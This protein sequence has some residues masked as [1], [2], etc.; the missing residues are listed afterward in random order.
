[1][2]YTAAYGSNST[3]TRGRCVV[4]EKTKKKLTQTRTKK[5]RIKFLYKS[6]VCMNMWKKFYVKFFQKQCVLVL[7]NYGHMLQWQHSR[8]RMVVIQQKQG[9]PCFWK[10]K[11]NTNTK[12]FHIKCLSMQMMHCKQ[13]LS[14]HGSNIWYVK[15]FHANVFKN[16]VHFVFVELRPYAAVFLNVTSCNLDLLSFNYF[17]FW[18]LQKKRGY[19][20]NF[21]N[22]NQV[23]SF[24]FTFL[25]M[26]YFNSMYFCF[27]QSYI[28]HLFA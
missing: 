23:I 4:S 11:K 5:F 9:T 22:P 12:I 16:K 24:C 18:N 17:F 8:Q 6:T 14:L 7:L 10:N 15:K 20:L 25:G 3:K 26:L 13:W 27:S 19:I 28:Q 21:S 2:T 1:M